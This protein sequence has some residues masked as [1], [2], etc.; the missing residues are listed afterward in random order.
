MH[1]RHQRVLG[2]ACKLALGAG[3]LGGV[4]YAYQA[5]RPWLSPRLPPEKK[6]IAA[7]PPKLSMDEAQ[8]EFLWDIEHHGLVLSRHGFRRLAEALSGADAPALA[9]LL[10]SSF[11]AQALHQP[12]EV[13]LADDTLDIV[14]QQDAGHPPAALS[15]E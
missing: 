4:L 9:A 2:W 7:A 1:S 3:V 11:S 14:R 6:A 8:R 12:C 5:H 10:A 15:R 13:R